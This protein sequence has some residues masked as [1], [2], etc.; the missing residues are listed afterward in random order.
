MKQPKKRKRG[1]QLKPRQRKSSSLNLRVLDDL[2]AKLEVASRASGRTLSEEAAWRLT[3]SFL[4]DNE[5]Q[6]VSQI[7]RGLGDV[8]VEGLMARGWRVELDDAERV[9]RSWLDDTP[10]DRG[11]IFMPPEEQQRLKQAA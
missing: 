9:V 7:Q 2:K 5:I 1:G 11:P 10:E 4:F 3:M 8:M 6:A